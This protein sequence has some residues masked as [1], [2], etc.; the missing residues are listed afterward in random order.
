MIGGKIIEVRP[1]TTEGG[2]VFIRL[3][4]VNISAA[5]GRWNEVAVYAAPYASAEAC[6]RRNISGVPE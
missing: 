5:E 6:E 4:C 2:I 1:T 3:W